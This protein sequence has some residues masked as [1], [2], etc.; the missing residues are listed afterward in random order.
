MA[1]IE[2]PTQAHV[3]SLGQAGEALSAVRNTLEANLTPQARLWVL[4]IPV[5]SATL[6]LALLKLD[7]ADSPVNET[8]IERAIQQL[9]AIP[10]AHP[11]TELY[12]PALRASLRSDLSAEEL[13][14][15]SVDSAAKA[16]YLCTFIYM[17]GTILRAPLGES[18]YAQIWLVRQ[19]EQGFLSR[20]SI[21]RE[22]AAPFFIRYWERACDRSGFEFRVRPLYAK[23]QVDSTE[24]SL[25]GLRRLLKE[26]RFCLGAPLPADAMAWLDRT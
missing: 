21:I 10:A 17:M 23:Q 4:L 5:I 19:M 24:K 1:T 11:S 3:D 13:H 7:S 8:V 22:I 20:Q 2:L 9:E 25:P 12:I 26:M 6:K 15:R 18:L 16:E 14:Q